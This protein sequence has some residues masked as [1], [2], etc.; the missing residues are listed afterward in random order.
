MRIKHRRSLKATCL[1]LSLF[2]ILL[3]PAWV[4]GQ[5]HGNGQTSSQTSRATPG[6]SHGP[7]VVA[8]WLAIRAIIRNFSSRPC[9]SCG[10]HTS[11]PAHICAQC[12]AQDER[13]TAAEASAQEQRRQEE[14][15]RAEEQRKREA[16]GRRTSAG[17][18]GTTNG[19]F[20][21]YEILGVRRGAS[22]EEIRSAY[23][24]LLMKHHPDKVMY[25]GQKFQNVAKDKT[26][27]IIRAYQI[28]TCNGTGN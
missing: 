4:Q 10:V 21:P 13:R 14:Q 8:L 22:K 11:N 12:Q 25:R 5:S 26:Q 16:E 6:V 3:S 24:K 19:G 23:L 18:R 2:T 27:Q 9:T 15:A 17:S 20:D 7:L 28:L 1:A